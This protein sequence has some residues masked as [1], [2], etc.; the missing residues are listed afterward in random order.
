MRE[1]V[2]DGAAGEGEARRAT[3]DSDSRVGKEGGRLSLG[4]SDSLK[5]EREEEEGGE[6][7]RLT[8][9]FGWSMRSW[10]R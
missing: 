10:S 8:C 6:L 5:G 3:P 4:G 1:E 9:R 2:S 7:Q